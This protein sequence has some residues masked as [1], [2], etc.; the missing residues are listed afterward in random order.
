MMRLATF[1]VVVVLAGTLQ[2][3]LLN[4]ISQL[5][6]EEAL[7][8]TPGRAVAVYGIGVEGQWDYPKFAVTLDEYDLERK[9]I[10]GGCWRYNHMKA[11]TP[12]TNKR[13]E[14][15]AFDVRPG[16][17][18]Y[19]GF[20]ASGLKGGPVAF[21]VPPNGAVYLGDFVYTSDRTVELRRSQSNPE[22]TTL[23]AVKPAP[24]PNIFLCAP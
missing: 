9:S 23:A 21:E 1:A 8:P 22:G 10:T 5:S 7:R 19:S 13:V 18:V 4:N 16:H 14:R 2:G 12:A 3:C 24:T 11:V 20:N 6:S 17:Y 15:F